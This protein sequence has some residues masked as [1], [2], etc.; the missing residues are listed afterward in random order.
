MAPKRSAARIHGL[1]AI[2]P[3]KVPITAAP[4]ANCRAAGHLNSRIDE[5]T[6]WRW[7]A[8]NQAA[9]V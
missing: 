5:L 7:K 2:R 6:P 4:G 8:I 1:A 9:A 3:S